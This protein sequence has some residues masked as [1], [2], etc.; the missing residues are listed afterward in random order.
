MTHGAAATNK[1]WSCLALALGL[2]AVAA[3]AQEAAPVAGLAWAQVLSAA[4][5]VQ[6]VPVPQQVCHAEQQAA[7]VENTGVG[8]LVGTVAGG[9]AG[10]ALGHGDGRVLATLF[11]LVV[12]AFWG[13]RAE[14]RPAAKTL[15][16]RHCTLQ[17]F[18]QPQVVGYDVRY[19]YAGQ[20]YRVQWPQDPGPTLAVRVT[21]V[22]GFLG[23]VA[24]T[25]LAQH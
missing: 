8:A 21:A 4:P 20:H 9:A 15:Q 18:L 14:G 1:R 10:N 16:V 19:A 12:G 7:P 24:T 11:G 2:A 22:G 6:H 25:G 3:G 23:P 5:V 13:D 17:S